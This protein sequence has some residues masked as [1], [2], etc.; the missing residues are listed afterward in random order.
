MGED[1][2][3]IYYTNM[4]KVSTGPFDL[5]LDFGLKLPTDPP[6]ADPGTH[7]TV[8]MSPAH[9]KAMAS[10]ILAHLVEA[11]ENWDNPPRQLGESS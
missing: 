5:V 11:D 8:I 7:F 10:I 1:P 9:A 2:P 4:V 6:E 3:P